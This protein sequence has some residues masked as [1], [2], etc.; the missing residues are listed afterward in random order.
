MNLNIEHIFEVAKKAL[1]EDA[2]DQT[3][4][5]LTRSS[6]VLAINLSEVFYTDKSIVPEV[7]KDAV[8]RLDAVEVALV[9]DSYITE[10]NLKT[11]EERKSESILIHVKSQSTQK[12]FSL[13]YTRTDTI[14]FKGITEINIDKGFN[15]FLELVFPRPRTIH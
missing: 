6:D 8:E 14:E 2:L 12:C 10:V 1:L 5:L 13:N 7:I 4:I 15:K 11:R 9:L 3:L